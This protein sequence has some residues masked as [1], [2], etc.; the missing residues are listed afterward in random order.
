MKTKYKIILLCIIS[1]I[2][3]ITIYLNPL[4][5]YRNYKLTNH[6]ESLTKKDMVKP[7]ELIPFDYDKVYVIYPYTTKK[8]TE[9]QIGTKSRYIKENNNDNYQTLIVTKD[10]KVISSTR[11]SLKYSFQ[12]LAEYNYYAKR[13]TLIKI[14]NSKDTTSFIEQ[15]EY[16]E[17]TFYDISY[18]LPGSYW[19][20]D[21]EEPGKF[22]YLDIDTPDNITIEKDDNFKLSKYLKTKQVLLEK[23]TYINNYKVKYLEYENILYSAQ[24]LEVSY[25]IDINESTYIF[26]LDSGI[27]SSKEKL[28]FY[29]E[30]LYNIVQSIKE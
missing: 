30:S 13:D 21:D 12:P 3:G 6:L 14:Y 7:N 2:I 22:Y 27:D 24:R 28:A 4:L 29:K 8:D 10:N 26:N 16:Y 20:E 19:E 1:F 18:T 25:I 15:R 23:D 11:I 9:K 5:I 17:D